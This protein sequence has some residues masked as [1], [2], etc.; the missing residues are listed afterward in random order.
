[1]GKLFSIKR[2]GEGFAIKQ[3][4]VLT[5]MEDLFNNGGEQE[6]WA[7]CQSLKPLKQFVFDVSYENMYRES[8]RLKKMCE[9]AQVWD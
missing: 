5:A 1:M 8:E 3:E 7:V 6:K 2:T 4:E 9:D